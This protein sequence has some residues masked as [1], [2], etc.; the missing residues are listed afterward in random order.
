MSNVRPRF[1][2]HWSTWIPVVAATLL[3]FA[4]GR[5][6][7]SFALIVVAVAL[8]AAVLTAVHH[9]EVVA[10]RVG[11]PFGT[12]ILAL[13]V[14][15]IEAALVVSMILSGGEGASAIARDTVYAA[16]MIV[17]NGVVGLC[18]LL[19]SL[20]HHEVEFRVDST[21]PSL[22]VLISLAVVVLVLPSFTTT[23]AG[24]TY[25][26][27]Q[28][29][30]VGVMSLVLYAAFVFFQTVR[31][32]DYFLPLETGNGAVDEHAAPPSL[33][34]TWLSLGLL[35]VCLVA[36]VGLAKMMAPVIQSGV[37]TMGA[38]AAV[39]GVIIAMLVLSPETVAAARA[40]RANRIQTSLN[41]ALGSALATI[42]LTIPVV[43]VLSVVLGFPLVLGLPGT[44][45]VLLALTLIVSV[46]T[47][48]SGRATVLQGTVHLVLFAAFLFLA[49]VP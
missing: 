7:G 4:W 10:H 35:L 5:S 9:A 46:L 19:G 48:A 33:R 30:F 49:I 2:L 15:V 16:I 31:H 25:S 17:C 26:V 13:A 41:L 22:S 34:E 40:A 8:I 21:S 37:S 44:E 14:T 45:M 39:V 11:E 1:M 42:G 27:S 47:L 38:P 6:L 20:R 29:A 32:R 24:P 12:L 3:A 23:T 18:L 43:A 36:V 28:L